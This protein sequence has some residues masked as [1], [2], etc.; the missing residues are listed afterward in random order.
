MSK[1]DDNRID[2]Q[3]GKTKIS[4]PSRQALPIIWFHEIRNTIIIV[5]FVIVMLLTA[6]KPIISV[7]WQWIVRLQLLSFSAVV[8][9]FFLLLSG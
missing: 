9:H 7:I 3:S 2:Y 4:G 8:V 1:K 5:V 6:G